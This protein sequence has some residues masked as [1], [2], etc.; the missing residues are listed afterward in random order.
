MQSRRALILLSGTCPYRKADPYPS[1]HA[2][3]RRSGEL[4][5]AQIF[6]RHRDAVVIE[7]LVIAAKIAAAIGA[8][9][10]ILRHHTDWRVRLA[11]E[12][13]RAAN[14]DRAVEI[15]IVD[16]VVEIADQ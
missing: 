7:L 2:R 16:I 14:I 9:M 4:L 13:G 8:A 15:E 6:E 12:S 11:F 3:H 5:F 10:K 1:G